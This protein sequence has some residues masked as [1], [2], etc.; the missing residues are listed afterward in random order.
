M[1]Q[2]KNKKAITIH[3]SDELATMIDL[4]RKEWGLRSRGDVLEHLLG[5]MVETTEADE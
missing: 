3:L 1:R 2:I 4:K 5:W